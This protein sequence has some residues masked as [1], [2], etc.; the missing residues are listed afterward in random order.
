MFSIASKAASLIPNMI[1]ETTA[2]ASSS[3]SCRTY[4]RC[5]GS[6]ITEWCVCCRLCDE[7]YSLPRCYSWGCTS[8]CTKCK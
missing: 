8:H 7:G 4:I 5:V 6:G 3:H 1:P 2:Q